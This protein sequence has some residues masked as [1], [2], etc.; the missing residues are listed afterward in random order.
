M[1]PQITTMNTSS[2]TAMVDRAYGKEQ[3]LQG[4]RGTLE[5]VIT[6]HFA[7][8]SAKNHLWKRDT[9]RMLLLHL[10]NESCFTILR[11]PDYIAVLAN[12]SSFGDKTVKDIQGWEKESFVPEEQLASLIKHC[13]AKYPTPEFLENVFASDNKIHMYWYV[14]LGRGDSVL[15]LSGFPVAFTNKM[16]HAFRLT[17]ATYTV[18]QAI[19]RAQAL[20]YGAT[21]KRADVIAWSALADSFEAEY[22]WS[23]VVHFVVKVNEDVT[24][25]KLQVV[26][27]YL[28]MFR[29]Q[30]PNMDM[31]G[32]TWE[33]LL[34]QAEEW[35]TEMA[36]KRDA[37]GYEQWKRVAIADFYKEE[38]EVTYYIIQL[39]NSVQLYEEGYEMSHC[40]ADYTYDCANGST[41]IFSLRKYAIGAA[42]FERMVT[43][44]VS[45]ASREIVEAKGKYN[46]MPTQTQDKLI[47]EWA[48]KEKLK[49]EYEYYD[50]FYEPPVNPAP[51]PAIQLPRQ[52]PR[53]AIDERYYVPPRYRQE[54]NDG[55][56]ALLLIGKIILY[57]ILSVIFM[58]LVFRW[59]LT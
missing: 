51:Q 17:P 52:M 49:P 56:E 23:T 48:A 50:G 15:T 20:G 44:E 55:T 21:A 8:M 28:E 58:M 4:N 11:S 26:L 54:D 25:D 53:V 30:Q 6:T 59:M 43:I 42:E 5:S 40:V 22:F 31:K 9:F 10:Y 24:I 38:D 32:R 57:I 36:K 3:E 34:R 33:A 37:E 7:Q 39:I 12:I 14:Q 35:H 27:E 41:A 13:F 47:M 2:F 46:E 45:P 18:A 1:E 29:A 19:R 16:A